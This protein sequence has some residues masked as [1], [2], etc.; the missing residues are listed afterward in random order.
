MYYLEGYDKYGTKVGARADSPCVDL[1]FLLRLAC[2]WSER[3]D[4]FIRSEN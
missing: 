4:T 2:L 1:E 3:E